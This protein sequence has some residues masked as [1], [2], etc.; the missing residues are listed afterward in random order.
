MF[1]LAPSMD[2]VGP[3]TRT[4]EDAAIMFEAMAGSDPHDPTSLP[5]PVPSVRA[6]LGRGIAGLRVGFDRRYHRQRGPRCRPG[7]G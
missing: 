1:A 3:M 7:D 2:H 6:D 4:V 5:D